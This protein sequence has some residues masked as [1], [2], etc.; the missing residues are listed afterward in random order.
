MKGFLIGV[1]AGVIIACT[2]Y[3]TNSGKIQRT[4][5]TT[6]TN[7]ITERITETNWIDKLRWV[8]CYRTNVIW[9]TNV[10]EKV[11]ERIKVI[12]QKAPDPIVEQPK[13]D[14]PEVITKSAPTAGTLRGP[15]PVKPVKGAGKPHIRTM[16]DGTVVTNFY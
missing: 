9:K 8:D 5:I 3:Q 4:V 10:T 12:E 15:R 2:W 6:T 16:L 14:K 1:I 11:V 13:D 7:T